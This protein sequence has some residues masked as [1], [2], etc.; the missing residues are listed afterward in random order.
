VKAVV[1]TTRGTGL[2]VMV[3]ATVALD[4]KDNNKQAL[5]VAII[6]TVDTYDAQGLCYFDA[7]FLALLQDILHN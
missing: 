7:M 1:I 2:M 6:N 3:V 4:L 5:C